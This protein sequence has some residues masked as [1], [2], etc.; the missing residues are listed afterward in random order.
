VRTEKA[1]EQMARASVLVYHL[2]TEYCT[3]SNGETADCI[4]LHNFII[5]LM[6]FT[7]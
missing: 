1:Q 7:N 3:G 4:N 6:A 5:K 2:Y